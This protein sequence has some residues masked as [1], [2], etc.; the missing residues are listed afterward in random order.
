[1]SADGRFV[2]FDSVLFPVG[3]N[4]H[5]IFLRDSCVGALN[6]CVPS[7]TLISVQLNGAASDGDSE[8]PSIS[9]DGRFVAYP[10]KATQQVAGDTNTF[11]DDFVR[12]TCFGAAPSCSPQTIRVSVRPDGTQSD[13]DDDLDQFVSLAGNGKAAAFASSASSL[14]PNDNNNAIDVFL[15]RTGFGQSTAVPAI[16]AACANCGVIFGHRRSATAAQIRR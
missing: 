6:P 8:F 7:T 16:G 9:A 11:I 4:F 14:A 10:S 12:D 2:T 1:M 5:Q 15:S 3:Q 13:H